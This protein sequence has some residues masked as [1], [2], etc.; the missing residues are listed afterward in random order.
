MLLYLQGLFIKGWTQSADVDHKIKNAGQWEKSHSNCLLEFKWALRHISGDCGSVRW[1]PMIVCAVCFSAAFNSLEHRQCF[2]NR[3][4]TNMPNRFAH[5]YN[6][7]HVY[8]LYQFKL[9]DVCR[10]AWF[11]S[12]L[13]FLV[14]VH[15]SSLFQYDQAHIS[16]ILQRRG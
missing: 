12:L 13:V 3:T 8:Y 15:I 7:A 1:I 9:Q 4:P 11:A 6:Y 14:R 5:K 10:A 2:C 16:D